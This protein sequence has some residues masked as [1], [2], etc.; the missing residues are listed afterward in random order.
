ME[1]KAPKLF[2]TD[3]APAEFHEAPE[4]FFRIQY[5]E[6]VDLVINSI[7]GFRVHLNVQDLLTKAATVNN[8]SMDYDF[9]KAFYVGDIDPLRL[10]SQ[11]SSSLLK[12]QFAT[13]KGTFSFLDV[14]NFF[15]TLTSARKEFF[16]S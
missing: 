10:R 9:I 2:D 13:H 12:T 8:Y 11:L 4:D 14:I 5:L 6:A 7:Q 1:R 16:Q 3:I 15:I